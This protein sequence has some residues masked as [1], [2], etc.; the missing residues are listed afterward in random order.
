MV[1][2]VLTGGEVRVKRN[3]NPSILTFKHRHAGYAF[4]ILFLYFMTLAIV[5]Y[6]MHCTVSLSE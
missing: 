2:F 1:L 5:G 4:H 6:S 3:S